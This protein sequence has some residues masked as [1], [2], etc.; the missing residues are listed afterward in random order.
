L[1]RLLALGLL[2]ALVGSLFPGC[3]DFQSNASNCVLAG[4]V[5]VGDG[6]CCGGHCASSTGTCDG[7][8]YPNGYYCAQS[9][10]CLSNDCNSTHTCVCTDDGGSCDSAPECCSGYCGDEGTCGP[11]MAGGDCDTDSDCC[12]GRTCSGPDSTCQ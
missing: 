11:C 5:C 12:G 10:D 3:Y 4:G 7:S 8:R 1:K 6:D 9:T 2:A